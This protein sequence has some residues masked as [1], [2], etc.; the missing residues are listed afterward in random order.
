MK[1]LLHILGMLLIVFLS[2]CEKQADLGETKLY[3]K[4]GISF[5][6]PEN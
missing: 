1:K 2:A 6:L 4:S 5:T 3:S